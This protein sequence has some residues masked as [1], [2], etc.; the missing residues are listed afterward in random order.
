MRDRQLYNLASQWPRGTSNSDIS[1]YGLHGYRKGGRQ[2]HPPINAP[3]AVWLITVV[4]DRQHVRT[5]DC[6]S[7]FTTT[8][9]GWIYPS[10]SIQAG[11]DR[12]SLSPCRTKR[13]HT[14]LMCSRLGRRR[15]PSSAINITARHQ[16]TGPAVWN[17]LPIGVI[18]LWGQGSFDVT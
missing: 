12:S 11:G 1:T 3:P 18:Q 9:T 15:S 4:V 7:C 2:E 13:Q 8:C 14:S 5:W 6:H 16:L 10:G 17:S